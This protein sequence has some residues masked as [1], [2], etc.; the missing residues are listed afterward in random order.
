M[1]ASLLLLCVVLC[2]KVFWQSEPPVGDVSCYCRIFARG[3]CPDSSCTRQ[4]AGKE[5]GTPKCFGTALDFRFC[6]EKGIF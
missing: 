3:L 6:L 4:H 5:V 2:L 1:K